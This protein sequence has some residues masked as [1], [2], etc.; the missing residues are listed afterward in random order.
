[1]I[2][3]SQLLSTALT[4]HL[5]VH[6]VDVT[7]NLGMNAA[8]ISKHDMSRLLEVSGGYRRISRQ[9]LPRIEIRRCRQ[10]WKESGLGDTRGSRS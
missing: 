8:H 10:T 4:L 7:V 9:Q 5:E 3:P 6:H 2:R 1:M